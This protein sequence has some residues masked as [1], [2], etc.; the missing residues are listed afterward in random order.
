MDI[1]EHYERLEL[2]LG[3]SN[4]EIKAAYKRLAIKYHPDK[5]NDPGAGEQFK[6]IS[7]S[8]QY[9]TNNDNTTTRMNNINNINANELF[10][11]FFKMNIGNQNININIGPSRMQN[12]FVSRQ[13]TISIQNGKRVEHIIETKNG[14]KTERTIITEIN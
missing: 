5:N 12:N 14:I 3:A 10:N 8:Y 2:N 1:K 13:S 4:E 6:K 9:L 11:Q 7:E